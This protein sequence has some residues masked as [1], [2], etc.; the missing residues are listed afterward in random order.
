MAKTCEV[1][2]RNLESER[3][4]IYQRKEV[5][6]DCLQK[7]DESNSASNETAKAS[8]TKFKTLLGYG[9]FLS[10]FGWIISIFSLI[11]IIV[12]FTSGEAIGIPIALMSILLLISS[13]LIVVI[14]QL[15]S[16]FVAIEKNTRNTYEL[17]ETTKS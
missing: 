12:G 15:I 17:L 8:K 10:G 14:G 7:L 4:H 6:F 1:C 3:A 2:G 9:K 5:C 11:M 16:C 13:I